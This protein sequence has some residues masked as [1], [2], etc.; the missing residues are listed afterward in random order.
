MFTIGN[1]NVII[2]SIISNIK[3]SIGMDPVRDRI[4]CIIDNMKKII[5]VENFN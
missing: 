5:Y 1:K 2:V 3:L 4:V